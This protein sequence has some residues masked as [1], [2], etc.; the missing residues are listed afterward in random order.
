MGRV[1]AEPDTTRNA[2][3]TFLAGCGVPALLE[4]GEPLLALRPG[5]YTLEQRSQSLVFTAWD[6]TRNW[7]RRV[8]GITRTERG[9]MTIAVQR[10]G[11]RSGEM[12]L[13]DLAHPR[14]EER[15]RKTARLVFRE[16]LRGMLQREFPAW[17]IRG[18][19]SE[20]DLEHSLSPAYVRALLVRGTT[21][22][23]AIGAPPENEDLPATLTFG[24][25]WLDHVRRLH[26]ELAV[27][28]LTLWVPAP[29]AP[30]LG[31]YLNLLDRS[32]ARFALYGYSDE[33]FAAPLDPND[34]G[35]ISTALDICRRPTDPPFEIPYAEPVPL[36][37]GEI[38]FRVAGLEFARYDGVRI[39]NRGDQLTLEDAKAIAA[40]IHAMRRAGAPSHAPLWQQN[41]EAWLESAV[42][43]DLAAIDST[44]VPAPIYGQVP[45][46]A[47]QSRTVIDLLA[48]DHAGRLAVIELKASQDLHLPLQA[49]DYWLRVK[50][51]LDRGEFTRFGYFPGRELRREAPRLLLVAPALGFHPATETVLQFFAPEVEVLR[52]GVGANWRRQLNVMFRL[53][54]AQKPC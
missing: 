43:Q 30:A 35:N 5:C 44:L 33:D 46:I 12:Q 31:V 34:Y 23:A 42:R 17:Q 27:S 36:A 13:V 41:P 10:F 37:S 54:G 40:S 21:A 11:N 49:L 38:S 16:R 15:F 32:K 1:L 18:L 6:D 39:G 25:I 14:N 28:A 53:P 26:P 20:P 24:L 3:E 7:M 50:W 52:I 47:G 22:I 2:I 48:C 4:P 51:H 8:A 19:S 45:A 9:R 29:A